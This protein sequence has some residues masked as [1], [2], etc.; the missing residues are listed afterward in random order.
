M[1]QAAIVV[2]SLA[3]A[4]ACDPQK[5]VPESDVKKSASPPARVEASEGRFSSLSECLS[6]CEKTETIPTN[7]E[8]CRLNCDTAY[9]AAARATVPAEDAIARV[10]SCFGRCQGVEGA[11]DE[12]A[13]SCKATA[14]QAASPPAPAVLDR[15]DT[16]IAGCYADKDVRPTDRATC[17]LN[18]AQVART[19]ATPP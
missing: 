12:C 5:S 10:A 17:E 13:S 6:S 16:C 9:G 8:T 3:F 1:N 7:R 14:A 18:C 2:L 15:L 19:V 11:P 4:V